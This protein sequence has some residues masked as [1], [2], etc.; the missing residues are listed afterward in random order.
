MTSRAKPIFT[1]KQYTDQQPWICIEYAT[2]EPGMTHD[3]FGFDLKT[4]TAF[5]KALEIAEYLNENLEHFTFTK[6]T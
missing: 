5:K 6:T 1:V 3:L 2:E 4:G